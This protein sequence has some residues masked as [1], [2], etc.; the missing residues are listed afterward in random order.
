MLPLAELQSAMVRALLAP[1]AAGRAAPEDWFS[2]QTPVSAA[3]RVH[4]NTVLG[5]CCNALR[6]SYPALECWLGEADFDALAADFARTHPPTEA[7]LDL[8]G[9]PFVSFVA[10]RVAPEVRPQAVELARFDWL[11]ERVAQQAPGFDLRRSWPLAAQLGLRL[12]ASLRL[13]ASHYAID[14]L[15]A[16]LLAGEQPDW[17]PLAQPQSLAVWRGEQGV[18]V[19]SLSPEAAAILGALLAGAEIETALE[20]AAD[21]DPARIA[22]VIGN[23][24]LRAGFVELTALDPIH[25]SQDGE[26]S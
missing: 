5:G 2:A 1:D 21:L 4:R 20:A 8:Y 6:L 26:Q 24:I 23:E 15:R 10:D 17:Q 22:D 19:R 18:L 25:H 14:S 16:G 13:H 7:A 9:E 11:F 12:A 3:L